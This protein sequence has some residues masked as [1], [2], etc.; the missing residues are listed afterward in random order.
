[1]STDQ[2]TTH[3]RLSADM[4]SQMQSLWILLQ[5][6]DARG[7]KPIYNT[8]WL[9]VLHEVAAHVDF[10]KHR[11]GR[12]CQDADQPLRELANKAVVIQVERAHNLSA[13]LLRLCR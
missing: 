12:R 11:H 2:L 10:D 8:F 5:I 7:L 1:M 3:N 4:R 9:M 6:Q 13:K